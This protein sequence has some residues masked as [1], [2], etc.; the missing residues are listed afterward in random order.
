M[1][2]S[3]LLLALSV[4]FAWGT[5]F[6]VIKWG[7]A[8]FPPLLFSALRFLLSAVPWVFLLPR[9]PVRWTLLAGVGTLL[10]LGQFGL[11][12]WAMQ[13]D[14]SPGLAS[15]VVQAQVFFTILLAM[16][17]RGERLRLVQSLALLLAV[18]GYAVVGW[19]GAT[20]P[21]ASITLLGLTM[22]LGAAF[23]WACSNTLVRSAGKVNMVALTTWA[24]LYG[25]M[26]VL[27]ASLLFEGPETIAH[28]LSH[29]S[30]HGWLAALW[31]AVGNTTFAFG[32]WNWLMAR[33]PAA[34]VAPTALL[35]PVFG[36]LS[37]AWLMAE[38]LPGWKLSAAMLVLGGLALNLYG[39]RL[40]APAQRRA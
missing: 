40:T 21:S 37:S 20:D 38:P 19:H 31:Q 32:A 7:L 1:P 28:A 13:H 18:A 27:L 29:A 33:H 39:G 25:T 16:M 36:M 26:P 30:P 15:L 3:H 14:I 12:Y 6:V 11:L 4:V 17:L 23:C 5:N 9:P 10:S 34:T 2:L 24:S 8:E 35:V 22:V